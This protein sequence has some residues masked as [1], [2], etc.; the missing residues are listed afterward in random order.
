MI[1][2]LDRAG[3][4]SEGIERMPHARANARV[5]RFSDGIERSPRTPE[6][7][8]VGSFADGIARAERRIGSFADGFERLGRDRRPRRDAARPQRVTQRPVEA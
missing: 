1:S 7:N 5:G 4:F 2:T 8:R 6:S 3:R